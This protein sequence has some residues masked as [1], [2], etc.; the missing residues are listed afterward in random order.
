MTNNIYVMKN[1]LS[2]R[3]ND[4]M[5]YP[6]DDYASKRITE[7]AKLNQQFKLEETELYKVA[8][9]DIETGKVTALENP[10]L[11]EIEEMSDQEFI[12]KQ[13]EKAN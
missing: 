1:V 7:F 12:E 9:I 8:V 10:V 4:V 6:T 13:E 5:Q 11:I 2:Q 3:Y